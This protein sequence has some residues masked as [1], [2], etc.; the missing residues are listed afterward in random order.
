[1]AGKAGN[2]EQALEQ[3]KTIWTNQELA[4]L[5]GTTRNR[6][7]SEASKVRRNQKP[8]WN[9]FVPIGEGKWKRA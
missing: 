9:G 7:S 3:S 4:E 1:M 8:H 2:D 6:V 5:F